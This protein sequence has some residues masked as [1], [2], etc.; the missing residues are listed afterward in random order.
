MSKSINFDIFTKEMQFS[1][2]FKD[3]ALYVCPI[4]TM[5]AVIL[6]LIVTIH[7]NKEILMSSVFGVQGRCG[8][9]GPPPQ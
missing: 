9:N 8:Y 6:T 4:L 7:I 5:M 3:F 2:E 1:Q